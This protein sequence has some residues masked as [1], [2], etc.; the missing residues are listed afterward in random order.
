MAENQDRLQI[1]SSLPIGPSALEE[2][3]GLP[4]GYFGIDPIGKVIKFKKSKLQEFDEDSEDYVAS[5]VI[6]FN[7]KLG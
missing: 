2:I 7:K 3:M 6:P 4:R 5:K 1:C